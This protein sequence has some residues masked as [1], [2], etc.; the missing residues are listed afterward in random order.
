M[1]FFGNRNHEIL[2][3]SGF[4]LWDPI[5]VNSS[6]SLHCNERLYPFDLQ[7]LTP[8]LYST[9]SLTIFLR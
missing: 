5:T 1:Y 9:A 8:I 4:I 2:P 3:V 7:E 6:V